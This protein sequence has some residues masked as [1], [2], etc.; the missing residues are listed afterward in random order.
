MKKKFKVRVA[1]HAAWGYRIEFANYYIF[2]S[3]NTIYQYLSLGADSNLSCYNPVLLSYNKAVEFAKE[4]KTIDD[5]H[6]FKIKEAV[7][8]SNSDD[9]RK[10]WILHHIPVETHE[11]L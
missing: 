4:L 9:K 3:W 5:V 6:K 7:K 8:K 2:K 10:E 1:H 11:V